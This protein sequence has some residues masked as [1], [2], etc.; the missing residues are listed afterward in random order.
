MLDKNKAQALIEV[1]ARCVSIDRLE[2]L[3]VGTVLDFNS[4]A[5][6]VQAIA[7]GDTIA[8][9]WSVEDVDSLEPD[10]EVEQISKDGEDDGLTWYHCYTHEMDTLMDNM[11]EECPA[12]ITTEQARAVLAAAAVNHDAEQG[13]NWDVLRAHLEDVRGQA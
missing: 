7:D 12:P 1:L 8:S 9:L 2:S 5:A 6:T 3:P 11:C 4:A 13:I 10:C